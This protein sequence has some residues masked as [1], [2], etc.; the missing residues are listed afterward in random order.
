MILE[1]VQV[2]SWGSLRWPVELVLH[3]RV[4]LVHAVNETGK[5]TLVAAIR[6]ALLEPVTANVDVYRPWGSEVA[7][8]AMVEFRTAGGRWRVEKAFS[9]RAHA[10]L[11]RETRGVWEPVADE[12]DTVHARTVALVTGAEVEQ[13]RRGREP[14]EAQKARQGVLY[15]LWQAQG[16]SPLDGL[17]LP[18]TAERDLAGAVGA[19]ILSDRDRRLMEAAE[20]RA[21]ELLTAKRREETGPL[22]AAAVRVQ[23]TRSFVEAQRERAKA[24]RVWEEKAESAAVLLRETVER[25]QEA[26]EARERVRQALAAAQASEEHLAQARRRLQ[27]ATQSWAQW[28][29][30]L[31]D[32]LESRQSLA[33]AQGECA[34]QAAA[35]QARRESLG[36]SRTEVEASAQ[37]WE[38]LQAAARQA[39]TAAQRARA[40]VDLA[41]ALAERVAIAGRLERA[42]PLEATIEET[43]RARRRISV[44]DDKGLDGLRALKSALAVEEAK[45]ESARV[46]VTFQAERMLRAEVDIDGEATAAD[47]PAGAR[48]AWEALEW[49]EVRLSGIGGLRVERAL[50]KSLTQQRKKVAELRTRWNDGLATWGAASLEVLQ[51]RAVEARAC[52]QRVDQSQATVQGLLPEGREAAEQALAQVVARI[53]TIRQTHPALVAEE[54]D[55]DRAAA[56]AEEAAAAALEQDKLVEAERSRVEGLRTRLAEG[57]RGLAAL[58]DAQH[59]VEKEIATLTGRIQTLED[60][61]LA[62]EERQARLAEAAATKAGAEG[63]VRRL[64][65]EAPSLETAQQGWRAAEREIEG[66]EEARLRLATEITAAQARAAGIAEEGAYTEWA[67][68]EESLELAAAQYQALRLR[69]D[70][71]DL[72]ART[73]VDARNRQ[74]SALFLPVEERVSR[75]WAR[76]SGGRYDAVRAD[77]HLR[78]HAVIP[79]DH[80]E[81]TPSPDVLSGGAQEQLGT[82]IRLALAEVLVATDPEKNGTTVVLDEPLAQSD[83]IRRRRVIEL[84]SDPPAGLQVVV[85]AHDRHDYASLRVD[86]AHDLTQ[87]VEQAREAAAAREP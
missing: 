64:E 72:L 21:S 66:L 4:N 7:P 84:L 74:R 57:E 50:E 86:A 55:P 2:E 34:R 15:V 17:D 70:A 58:E 5:T 9:R 28:Q 37:R 61:G 85:L 76:V 80:P 1:R 60:D 68:A 12:P 59:Q 81:E 14:A 71:R 51:E 16:R 6:Y 48:V 31:N 40:R 77:G 78:P 69:A 33:A 67:R 53:Q 19:A 73:L 36:F 79:R 25:L 75:L 45:L 10:R 65:A 83:S 8:R 62:E 87:L 63:E 39:A 54:P 30:K 52:D 46:R 22:A 41:R 3:P 35:L 29:K 24:L 42:A 23:D 32:L 20:R 47:V 38:A 27:E 82:I 11:S 13:R 49:A 44:P 26:G 56:E 18:G 43:L